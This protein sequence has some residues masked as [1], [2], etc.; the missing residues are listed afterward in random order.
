V[1]PVR[2]DAELRYH[3]WVADNIN[4][5]LKATDGKVGYM[6]ITAM[7]SGGIGEFDKYW[8]HSGTRRD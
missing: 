1:S 4:Y 2:Y 7:G 6:H 3:R 8:R 5:V